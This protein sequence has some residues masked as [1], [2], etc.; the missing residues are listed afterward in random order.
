MLKRISNVNHPTELA[1]TQYFCQEPLV[2]HPR[3]H[4]VPLDEVLTIPDVPN[5]VILV[6]PLLR[7][8]N[9]PPMETVGEAVEF[10][11]QIFEVTLFPYNVVIPGLTVRASCRACNSFISA[12]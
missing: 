11:R 5:T 3:N 9:S 7:M 4:C 10:F 12:T 6:I 1:I 2:S 8:F